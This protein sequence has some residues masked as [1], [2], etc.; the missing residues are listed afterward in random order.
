MT[1][2]MVAVLVHAADARAC[3]TGGAGAAY[4]VRHHTSANALLATLDEMH[5]VL[6]VID[7]IDASGHSM[8]STAATIRISYP[9]VPVL[10]YCTL[11][12]S[13]SSA[14]LDVACAGVTSLVFRGVDDPGFA[15]RAAMRSSWQRAITA[16]VY[17]AVVPYLPAAAHPLLRYAI[18]RAADDPSVEDAARGLGVDRK[19]L[20]NWMR[21]WGDV[22]PR[23][24][25][26]W[27]R[28][29][30]GVGM[31]EDP[32]RTAEH[33]ALEL[34]FASGTAFRNMLR[35][36]VGATSSEIRNTGGFE[37]VLTHFTS[38]LA[39]ARDSER[40]QLNSM[41]EHEIRER[42]WSRRA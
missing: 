40:E 42:V 7:A 26:N 21:R 17:A 5:V 16:R 11:S 4:S 6:V 24:F 27:I 9:T 3:V 33:V 1:K 18:G 15:M 37:R 35:R 41:A 23:E 14:V 30:I 8:A 19:T 2:P 39:V 12:P 22:G 25:I 13:A 36:Y 38:R 31:L 29:A 10:A 32:K 34:G 20:F 28:L